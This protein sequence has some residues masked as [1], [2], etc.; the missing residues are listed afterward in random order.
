M[1]VAEGADIDRLCQGAVAAKRHITGNGG[2]TFGGK[3]RAIANGQL[4][5]LQ[6]V[7]GQRCDRDGLIVAVY[8]TR[9]V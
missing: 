8:Q 9:K 1:L 6:C 4:H 7:L 5:V 3:R 2:V